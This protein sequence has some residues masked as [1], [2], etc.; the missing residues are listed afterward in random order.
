M[1]KNGL[2]K[3]YHPKKHGVFASQEKN[4]EIIIESSKNDTKNERKGIIKIG[5]LG[6][7]TEIVVTQM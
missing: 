2:L 1:R 3:M 5:C 7:I 6:E 4:N